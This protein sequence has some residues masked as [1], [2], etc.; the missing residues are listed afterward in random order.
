MKRETARLTNGAFA[1]R[2]RNHVLSDPLINIVR[3]KL[4]GE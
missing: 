3:I 1:A 4:M 2:S